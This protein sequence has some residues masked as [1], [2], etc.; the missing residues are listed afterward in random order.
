VRIGVN[1]SPEPFSNIALSVLEDAGS[2]GLSLLAAFH[3]V[4]T[5]TIV[6]LFLL[7][8]IPDRVTLARGIRGLFRGLRLE[9][10][11]GGLCSIC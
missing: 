10:E 6:S 7:L 5:L 8:G 1:A 9:W 11:E 2:T 4:L 3:P